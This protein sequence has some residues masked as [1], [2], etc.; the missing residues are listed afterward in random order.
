MLVILSFFCVGSLI[1]AEDEPEGIRK[2]RWDFVGFAGVATS[3][4]LDRSEGP[5]DVELEIDDAPLVGIRG[6]AHLG[7]RVAFGMAFAF[8]RPNFRAKAE[9]FGMTDS[10]RGDLSL[11]WIDADVT[12]RF[13]KKTTTPYARLG[14]G[15]FNIAEKHVGNVFFAEQHFQYHGGAGFEWLVGEHLVMNVDVRATVTELDLWPDDLIFVQGTFGIGYRSG[16][17]R[18]SKYD[19][20]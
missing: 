20:Y 14:I 15:W 6:E 3:N 4:T 10:E 12:W 7:E 19:P 13:R 2:G 9:A 16:P 8:A 11:N 5:V 18:Q 17:R 1:A